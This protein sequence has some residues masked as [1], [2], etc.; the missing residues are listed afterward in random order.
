MFHLFI[1]SNSL[2][3]EKTSLFI[4]ADFIRSL[5]KVELIAKERLAMESFT[6]LKQPSASLYL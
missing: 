4:L 5:S 1:Y 2:Y 3:R 6:V